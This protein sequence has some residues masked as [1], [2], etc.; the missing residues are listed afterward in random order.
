MSRRFT[1]ADRGRR[2]LNVYVG[3]ITP[4]GEL[5]QDFCSTFI[6]IQDNFNVC[7]VTRIVVQGS[8]MNPNDEPVKDVDV[9]LEGSE[10]NMITG[11]NG[12]FNFADVASGANY[13]IAPSKKDDYLNGVSTLDLVMIQRHILGIEKLNTP[14]KLIAADVNNDKNITASDLS[15]LRKVI[16]GVT[17]EFTNNGSWKF[18]DK[19]YNFA[20]P[21]TAHTEALPLVYNLENLATDM[22]VDFMAVKIGDVNGN[23]KAN[24]N[25]NTTEARTSQKML[26]STANQSFEAG[27]TIEVPVAMAHSNDVSGFQFTVNFNTELFSLEAINSPLKGINDNNFGL[28]QLADGQVTV[29]Y[30][31]ESAIDMAEGDALLVLTLRAK[32][33]GNLT[34]GLWIDSAITKAEAYNSEFNVMNVAFTV[35]NRNDLSNTLYQNTPNPF[36]SITTIGFEL[37]QQADATLTVFDVTGKTVMVITNNFNKG[38]NSIEINRNELG[39]SGVLYYTLESGDFKATRK[40]VVVE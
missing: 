3:V 25:D 39:A 9:K 32:T 16:L 37:A 28:T 23:A 10:M 7:P 22:N 36:K 1:C 2:D 26:L 14:H 4:T 34:N 11:N 12:T 35:E 5:I 40:M 27:Q 20:D 15:D 19:A 17:N 33:K 29:S 8:I 6:T 21:K 31:K 38:Y 13:I 18:F 30:N 24:L